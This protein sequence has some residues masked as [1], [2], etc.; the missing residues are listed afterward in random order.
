[1]ANPNKKRKRREGKKQI[2][3]ETVRE[4]ERRREGEKQREK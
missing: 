1:M 4:K 2:Q 3:R